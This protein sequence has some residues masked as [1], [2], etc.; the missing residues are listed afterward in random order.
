[1]KFAFAG[2]VSLA[3]RSSRFSYERGH[4]REEIGSYVRRRDS[5]TIMSS[6]RQLS[7]GE[8][9]KI[10]SC[11]ELQTRHGGLIFQFW[12]QREQQNMWELPLYFKDKNQRT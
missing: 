6:C 11:F 5:K 2:F 9:N 8:K 10:Y 3:Q 12:R 7:S 4:P 1:M